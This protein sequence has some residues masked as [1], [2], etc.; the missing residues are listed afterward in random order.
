MAKRI[1]THNAER[2]LA[3]LDKYILHK[4]ITVESLSEQ[5]LIADEDNDFIIIPAECIIVITICG[6]DIRVVIREY[7]IGG[8]VFI[9]SA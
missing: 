8:R 5:E 3:V 9:E 1:G 6:D 4:G 2:I 7:E